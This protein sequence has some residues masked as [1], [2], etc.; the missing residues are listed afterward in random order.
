VLAGDEA[1]VSGFEAT[2]KTRV[3]CSPPSVATLHAAVRALAVNRSRGDALRWRLARLV[4]RARAGLQRAGFPVTGGLFPIQTLATVRGDRAR[5]LHAH[6]AQRGVSTILRQG[7]TGEDFRLT[8][9]FTA[10]HAPEDVDGLS[11]AMA[12]AAAATEVDAV[13][14]VSRGVGP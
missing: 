2:S 4:C 12:Q 14:R 9:L 13:D 3:H 6:L 11:E 1:I 10:R 8:L 7:S 5:R